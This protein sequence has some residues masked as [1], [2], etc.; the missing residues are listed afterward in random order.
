MKFTFNLKSLLMSRLS[1][2]DLFDLLGEAVNEA[3]DGVF[4][5]S[6]VSEKAVALTSDNFS[7]FVRRNGPCS[8]GQLQIWSRFNDG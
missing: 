2:L 5:H 8:S 6:S 4:I 7:F 3:E 1:K